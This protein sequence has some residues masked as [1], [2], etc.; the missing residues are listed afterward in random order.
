[1]RGVWVNESDGVTPLLGE[2]WPGR[3]VFPDFTGDECER[4]WVEECRRFQQEV[5]FDG[6]WIDMNEVASFVYGST[7][8]C[9]QNELNYPPYTP[10]VVDRLLFSK[11]LC[12]DAAQA[13]GRHYD[14][15]NLYGYAMTLAS[16]RAI[17]TLFP[18]KCSFLLAGS[19]KFVGHWLGDNAATWEQLRWAISGMLEFGLFGI[20]YIG[21]DICGFFEDVTE[22]LCRRWMQVG[23]FYPFSRNHNTEKCTAQDPAV[24]GADSLLAA[25]SRHYLR[26]RYWLLP[27]H[28]SLFHRAHTRGDTVARP[29]LHEFYAEEATWDVDKQFLWGPELLITPVLEP[30]VE[31]IQAY[32]PNATWYE[33]ESG[34]AAGWRGQWAELHLPPDR[35]GLHVRGGHVVPTQEPATTTAASRRNPLG[36]IVALDENG[37]AA[38]ELFWDDGESTGT[39]SSKS[40]IFYEFRVSN[41]VLTLTAT[42]NNYSDPHALRFEEIRVL[43]LPQEQ[44]EVTVTEGGA[45]LSSAHNVTYSPAHKLAVIAG[46]R[47]ALGGS[48]ALSW[49]LGTRQSERFDCHLG[50]GAAP[51]TCRRLGC[52][53]SETTSEQGMPYCYYSSPDNGY[54]VSEV[55]ATSWGV[56]ANLTLDGS[57][58]GSGQRAT[59]PIGTLRLAVRQHTDRLLQLK[60][61]DYANK[62]YE[63]PVQLNLPA[64]PTSTAQSRLYDVTVLRKPFG[65]QVRRRSSGTVIWDSQLPTFTFSDMF[66]QISTHLPSANLYGFGESE[67][68]AFRRDL[69]WHT[70]GMFARDQPPGYKLNSYG[71]QPFYMGLEEDGNAHGV[72][73]LN[74][75]AMDVTFQ[76]TPALTF[77]TTG[78]IL[79]FYLV[80]GPTPELVVQEYTQLVGRPVMPPYW[81]LGFQLCR[82]GYENDT[83]IAT[84]VEDMKAAR[85][86]YDIQYADIDY[87]ERQLDF[88]LS[89]HFSGLPALVDKLHAEGMRFVLILDPAISANETDYPAFSRG[90][91]Q[92]VFI[93][94]PQSDD[95]IF[96]KVWP[97]FPNIVVNNSLDWDTQVELYR[98]YVAFPDFFRN[99]T[100]EWWAREITEVYNNP[101]NASRSLKFDGIWIDMN[102]PSNFV[103]GAVGGCRNQELNFPPYIPLKSRGRLGSQIQKL[104]SQF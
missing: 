2:V 71:V 102:E 97:D 7:K 1:S 42:H 26:L 30:G 104:G 100:I 80:L 16:Q 94:W 79:D 35:L 41:N 45:T 89:P 13:W 77:R 98:A 84:L 95:I 87:M 85:I 20:P 57:R 99:S 23:A 74:S 6:L 25:S 40:Y 86:P 4:W 5:P 60:I 52:T 90:L 31:V 51:D 3:T 88:T 62:L 33:L 73:L 29:L 36:L 15:H 78:G 44:L 17:K 66:L 70:W 37:E 55:T 65:V 72:L 91:A 24:F 61:Y 34:A 96:A 75:N 46:L 101:Y 11:T 27:H 22:E 12:M 67:H 38:G 10:Q 63:V 39:V 49:R 103:N 53:W 48:Y 58:S 64:S 9:S 76:P 83:E 43:G 69:C 18:G 68:P 59:E 8:G 93:K 47:L 92:D 32:F 28:Y 54:V 21:A 82:Y 56:V 14:V 19:G 50:L 81:A